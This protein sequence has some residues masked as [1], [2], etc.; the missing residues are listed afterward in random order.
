MTY[1]LSPNQ[2]ENIIYFIQ[3]LKKLQDAGQ[4]KFIA[5]VATHMIEAAYKNLPKK[6]RKSDIK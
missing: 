5:P 6:H 3:E 2:T 1:K 4:M